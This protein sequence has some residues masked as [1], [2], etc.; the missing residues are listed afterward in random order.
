ML[1]DLIA[2]MEALT[3]CQLVEQ[4]RTRSS[5]VVMKSKK[6]DK[7]RLQLLVG[8]QEKSPLQ[9]FLENITTLGK[10]EVASPKL[11]F[12]LGYTSC[13]LRTVTS[14]SATTTVM[15]EFSNRL[16]GHSS[17]E[18]CHFWFWPRCKRG[19]N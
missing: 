10:Q 6:M 9:S 18:T 19:P 2:V 12:N 11:V 13:L 15:M 5:L 4:T 3:M 8:L 7:N 17:E 14:R 1:A 16:V